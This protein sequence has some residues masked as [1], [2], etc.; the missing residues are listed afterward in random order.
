[1]VESKGQNTPKGRLAR[2]YARA[3]MLEYQDLSLKKLDTIFTRSDRVFQ[4]GAFRKKPKLTLEAMA[5]TLYPTFPKKPAM[6]DW[7]KKY[8]RL[9]YCAG[10]KVEGASIE[11]ATGERTYVEDCLFCV[12]CRY[13][14]NDRYVY[15]NLRPT[16]V[17]SVHMLQRAIERGAIFK[18]SIHDDLEVILSRISS[19][20]RHV[21]AITDLN[22]QRGSYL[23]PWNCG[24]IACTRTK[25]RLPDS[26]ET[27]WMIAARTYLSPEMITTEQK[28]RIAPLWDA[29]WNVCRGDPQRWTNEEWERSLRANLAL[30]P[31]FSEGP[32]PSES[33]AQESDHSSLDL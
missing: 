32:E 24:A 26:E 7:E 16:A 1:M 13:I 18:T 12:E 3:A 27:Q 4:K 33:P 5:K 11:S 9:C 6:L 30:I 2:G 28:R 20:G 25:V 8:S 23:L 10:L 19:L 14:R 15:S 21:R 29:P 31:D 17:L 22:M